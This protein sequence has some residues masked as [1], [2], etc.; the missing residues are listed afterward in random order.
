MA[1]KEKIL[2]ILRDVQ[3][4]SNFKVFYAIYESLATEAANLE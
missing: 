3:E 4:D 1:E 2:A